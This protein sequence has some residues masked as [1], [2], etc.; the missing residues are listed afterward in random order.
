MYRDDELGPR[1]PL[2]LV[3]GDL[4]VSNVVRRVVLT[5][6]SEHAVRLMVGARG[7]DA[8]A[9]RELTSGN[10]FFVTEVLANPGAELLPTVRDAVLARVARLS[11][12]AQELMQAAAVAGPRIESWLLAA[13]GM[14][15]T[16]AMDECLAMGMLVSHVD[17]LAFRHELARQVV[18]QSMSPPR[19]VEL[20][21][22]V[23]GALRAPQSGR[24]DAAR[25][26]HHAAGA[27]DATAILEH[28][29]AAARQAAEATAHREAAVLYGLALT[30]A[31]DLA[32]SE[33]A[34]LLEAYFLGMQRH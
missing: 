10:P 30:C 15:D 17:V 6:L 31:S 4:A 20:H 12:P 28:A 29:S 34:T 11:V 8:T 2:R 14:A 23:L 22:R 27:Q 25:L 18:L 26:A 16:R 9:L 32:P 19:L 7:L 5:P 24:I 21:R 1:N 13:V 3:L 33:R